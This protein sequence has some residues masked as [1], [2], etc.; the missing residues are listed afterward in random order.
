[1]RHLRLPKSSFA[2][3]IFSLDRMRLQARR[4]PAVINDGGLH[5]YY[6]LA[7]VRLSVVSS[8]GPVDFNELLMGH[9]KDFQGLPAIAFIEME[10][11]E[12]AGD[13]ESGSIRDLPYS[14]IEHLRR[15]LL[16]VRTKE[17]PTKIFDL[18]GSGGFLYRVL[19]EGVFIGN[20]R[21]APVLYAM[22]GI[23][24]QRRNY[25]D[26]WRSANV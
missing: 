14:N 4:G 19:K 23:E 21:E 6:E 11:G 15:C 18:S 9:Q 25:R 10:L 17:I 16:E 13:P 5:L 8:L 12:L 20:R 26:W 24:E 1:M 2:T 3:C 7:P 22:P